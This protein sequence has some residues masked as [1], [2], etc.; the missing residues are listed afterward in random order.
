MGLGI[1]LLVLPPLFKGGRNFLAWAAA[2]AAAAAAT[3]ALSTTAA[4]E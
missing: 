1:Y 2:A 3:A 4:V